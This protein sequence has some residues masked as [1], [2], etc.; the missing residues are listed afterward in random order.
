[1]H[2]F[3]QKEGGPDG[4]KLFFFKSCFLEKR[5][6]WCCMWLSAGWSFDSVTQF[7]PGLAERLASVQDL[8]DTG[9]WQVL[10]KEEEK[11]EREHYYQGDVHLQV[12][13]YSLGLTPELSHYLMPFWVKWFHFSETQ[14]SCM[15]SREKNSFS[16]SM[17]PILDL[18]SQGRKFFFCFR[19]LRVPV[20]TEVSEAHWNI[21]NVSLYTAERSPSPQTL[22]L[23]PFPHPILLRGIDALAGL[24]GEKGNGK[25]AGGLGSTVEHPACLTCWVGGG[26]MF[27]ISNDHY[28]QSNNS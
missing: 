2:W 12:A 16:W 3:G 14:D 8:K 10:Q 21:F 9:L 18:G 13:A 4:Y 26:K 27:T 5:G 19:L 7:Q 20:L 24:H 22:Y 17:L 25:R 1:M 15:Q 6:L 11:L 28:H 23:S